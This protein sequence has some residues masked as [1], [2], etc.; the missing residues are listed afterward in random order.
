MGYEK[1]LNFIR[2]A[3]RS[4][5]EEHGNAARAQKQKRAFDVVTEIDLS[6][7][8]ALTAAIKTA[9]PKDRVLGE[10]FSSQTAVQGRTWTLD[11]IDGTFNMANGSPLFGVQAALIEDGDVAVSA[12]YLPHFQEEIYAVKGE[13][14]YCNGA[15]LQVN[16]G[17]ALQNS[18]ISFGVQG[19]S[20]GVD[21]SVSNYIYENG[22]V[23]TSECSWLRKQFHYSAAAVFENGTNRPLLTLIRGKVIHCVPEHQDKLKEEKD[24]TDESR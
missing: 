23:V 6:I 24:F 21:D 20:G 2:A 3:L 15:R 22:P 19:T 13:G 8:R 11:P 18:L 16:G 1:E 12:V 5:Y 4:A 17:V 9:F 7:E 10:E 14:A